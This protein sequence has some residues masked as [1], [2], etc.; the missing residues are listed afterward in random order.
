MHFS[1]LVRDPPA[2]RPTVHGASADSK[3]VGARNLG[4]LQPPGGKRP[5][6]YNQVGF[7]ERDQHPRAPWPRHRQ[8]PHPATGLLQL[9]QLREVTH[10]SGREAAAA[11]LLPGRFGIQQKDGM[12]TLR[13]KLCGTA[14]GRPRADD[15]KV[16]EFARPQRRRRTEIQRGTP[17]Q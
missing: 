14:A 6:T 4:P 7:R 5:P 17:A 12:S 13:E 10:G 8:L 1:A 16:P 9:P 15:D 11:G 3:E 2:T